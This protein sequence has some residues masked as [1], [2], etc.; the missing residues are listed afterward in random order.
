MASGDRSVLFRNVNALFN[1]GAIGGLT[2]RELLDRF[3]SERG[4]ASELAFGALVHR[5]GPMV[6]GVCRS[7]LRDAHD[8]E[9][10]YQ[11]TFL[12]LARKASSIRA[13]DS[14]AH[15]LYGVARRVAIRLKADA[16]R[17]RSRERQAAAP[18]EWREAEGGRAAPSAAIHEEI[19]RLPEKYRAPLVICCLE[20]MTYETAARSLQL[21]E[22]AVRGRLARARELLK[23]RLARLGLALP[24]GLVPEA[25]A[26]VRPELAESTIR[27]AVRI[28]A[29]RWATS[30]AV[31]T[32]VASLTERVRN[33]MLFS[34]MMRMSCAAIAIG[35]ASV[36]VYALRGSEAR[37]G[38][39]GVEPTAAALPGDPVKVDDELARAAPGRIV[40]ASSL[41]KDCMVLSYIPDWAFGNL[42]NIA[43][44]NNDGGVRT[45][46]KWADIS[47]E[48]ATAPDRKFLIALY[49][50][51][52]TS[53]GPS[54][55]ILAF[56][57]TKDW[58]ERTSW[59]TKPDH[60]MEPA[61]TY[62]FEP[63]QG[64][65]LFDVT[66]LVQAQAKERRKGNGIVLRFLSE[67]RPGLNED[68]SG[69]AF[70]SREGADDWAGRRP[71]FLVVEPAK[72]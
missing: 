41:A 28:A 25:S 68:W 27:A 40:R 50:R 14:P 55:P 71:L 70:V 52:T 35:S 3:L 2:D 17:R 51:K 19:G 22:G 45:I 58:P 7:M 33:A 59:K 32:S 61:G 12:L 1:I 34:K 46:L 49:S 67:D 64:W 65:K 20:G 42:D 36:G 24:A 60:A 69:Y 21:T 44:A 48:E 15:W 30:G 39:E 13:R 9:D 53:N 8:A 66:A 43:I 29:D 10:A 6:L 26:A 11:A 72:K 62:K 5:H 18:E 37:V 23:S 63:G 54:G 56:E 47:P 38:P 16:A 31:S 57:V 4:E